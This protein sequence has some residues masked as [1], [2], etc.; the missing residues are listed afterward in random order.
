MKTLGQLVPAV[1]AGVIGFA[2]ACGGDS[3]GPKAGSVTGIFGDND[4]VLTGGTLSVG[5]TV[6]GADGFPLRGASVTWAVTPTSAAA[7]NPAS[8]TSDSIGHVAAAVRVGSTVGAF[9]VT[10]NLNGVAPI[11]FHLKALDPCRYF[12]PYALGDTVR[13]ALATTDCLNGSWY[14]DFYALTLPAGPQ[15]LRIN[16]RSSDTTFDAWVDL[17]DSTGRIVGF[18]D[19]SILGVRRNSQLDIIL[20]GGRYIIGANAYRAFTVGP[21]LLTTELRSATMRG[22]RQVWVTRGV[23]VNDSVTLSDC[24]DSVTPTHYYDVARVFAFSGTRLSIA[25]RSTAI[26]PTLALYRVYP[27]NLYARRLLVSNDDSSATNTN[28]FIS[29]AADSTSTYDIILGTSAAGQTGDRKS[30]V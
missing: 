26:N 20:P 13:G 21:Y 22:C 2:A 17:Y 29:F 4:S 6:L 1:L 9:T 14:D 10:A 28:A 12:A 8:Q 5:F 16:M 11:N 27:G 15:S 7:V 24:A 3:T 30:V 18:D 19:D 25:L 23:S